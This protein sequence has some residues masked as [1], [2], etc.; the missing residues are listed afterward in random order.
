[1]IFEWF[2]VMNGPVNLLHYFIRRTLLGL[3]LINDKSGK[4]ESVLPPFT[5]SIK[6]S[7]CPLFIGVY[8]CSSASLVVISV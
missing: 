3:S 6:M 2:I 5:A 7:G 8:I 4:S 1:M